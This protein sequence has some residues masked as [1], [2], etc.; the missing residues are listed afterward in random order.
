MAKTVF[1]FKFWFSRHQDFSRTT[2]EQEIIA[3]S[4]M[5]YEIQHNL[6]LSVNLAKATDYPE[7]PGM[8]VIKHLELS[9]LK[10]GK[11]EAEL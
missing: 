7:C 1:A 11:F 10:L 9:G 3:F 4:E 5:G 8:R 2:F 6:F